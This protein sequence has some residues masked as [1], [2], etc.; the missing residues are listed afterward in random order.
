MADPFAAR[1]KELESGGD[2]PFS[3][4]LQELASAS[5]APSDVPA[6][7][8]TPKKPEE[9]SFLARAADQIGEGIGHIGAVAKAQGGRLLDAVTSPIKSAQANWSPEGIAQNAA[10]RRELLRG[11]DDITMLGHGQR[12]AGAV[13]DALGDEARG[14]SLNQTRE[15]D[16]KAAPD[17]R[18]ATQFVAPFILPNPVG[19][20][21]KTGGAFLEGAAPQAMAKVLQLG[22]KVPAPVAGLAAYEATAP[23]AAGLSADAGGHR[24]ESAKAAAQDPLGTSLSVIAPGIA[25]VFKKGVLN[26][27]GAQAR[28]LIEERGNGATVGLRTPG[29]GG[30]FDAE[31]AGVPANDRGIGIAGKRGATAAIDN[32]EQA[33]ADAHGYDYRGGPELERQAARDVKDTN[34]SAAQD[35]RQAGRETY[36][37]VQRAERDAREF[38][39][40]QA[41]TLLSA[42]DERH[43]VEGSEPYRVLS[44]VID[45]QSSQ[46]PPRDAAEL[47]SHIDNSLHDLGTPG[48]VIAQLGS[49]RSRMETRRDP[50]SGRILLSEREL[51]ALRGNLMDLAKIGNTDAPRGHDAPLRRAAFL[52]KEMVDQGPYAALN[53]LY[54]E[55]ASAREAGR[56]SL[57]LP[58]RLGR[59]RAVEERKLKGQ[60][61]RSVADPT[62]MPAEAPPEASMAPYR[63]RI[64]G[65]KANLGVVRDMAETRQRG[66]LADQAAT[67]DR[68][69]AGSAAAVPDRRLLGLSERIGPR[70]TDINQT[71][72]AF[73]RDA[74]QT[75]TAGGNPSDLDAFRAAHPELAL[76]TRLPALQSAKADLSFSPAPV[77]GGIM[78]R[79][80][81]GLAGPVGAAGMMALGHGGLPAAAMIGLHQALV[82]RKAIA[83]RVLYTPAQKL[84]PIGIAKALGVS[85]GVADADLGEKVKAALEAKKMELRQ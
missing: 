6:Q 45:R 68:V 10:E 78:E 52:A 19:I 24:L 47:V 29:S 82:N 49:I 33:H 2:D 71:K 4:R 5:G 1:L 27:E 59:D 11:V 73:M 84:N 9:R 60:M 61:V 37:E 43:R 56:E 26:S 64:E 80:A 75:K 23:V 21:G 74:E 48:D 25:S 76:S 13:G 36:G 77:H 46:L 18:A 14:T 34:R 65:A 7:A 58:G 44:D 28:R 70:K 32:M 67:R 15:A 69:A 38:A 40:E 41:P 63:E 30:V 50:A 12:L 66:A 83:G 20:A 16:A 8:A 35:M 62:V 51:N 81:G 72:L 31:L 79:T 54:A 3:A 57:G 42:L 17:V 39:T 53:Q 22:Q 85:R 55:S